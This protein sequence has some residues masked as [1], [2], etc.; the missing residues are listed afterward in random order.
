[1]TPWSEPIAQKPPHWWEGVKTFWP[2]IAMF[3][4]GLI[5][6]GAL[7]ADV[8]QLKEGQEV[9]R[10]DHDTIVRIETRQESMQDDVDAIKRDVKA[11]AEAVQP[12]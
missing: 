11:I 7:R 4:G 3:T 10:E 1:M 5:G 8:A 2:L 9:A 6:Y 12:R